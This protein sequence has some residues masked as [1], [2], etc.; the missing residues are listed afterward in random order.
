MPTPF[1]AQLKHGSDGGVRRR[2]CS[3]LLGLSLLAWLSG[4]EGDAT[5]APQAP[6]TSAIQSPAQGSLPAG[7]A[8]IEAGNY[9]VPKSEWSVADF[10]VTFPRGWTVQYG[11]V[12][13]KNSGAADELGFV[14]VEVDEIFTDACKGGDDVTEV[15]PSVYD[16]STALLRQPGPRAQGL[17]RATFGGY[18][19]I[20]VNLSVPKNLNL[21]ACSLGGIGLQ[22]WYSAPADKH[23]VLLHDG[24]ASVYILDIDGQRQ[25]F[26]VQHRSAASPK[27]IR[28]LQAVIDSIHI[29]G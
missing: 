21:K 23:F 22:I 3:L 28:E 17:F 9:L 26:L 29:E 24:V 18:P 14:A 27:D 4:C 19:A 16:L 25:V 7:T 12:Y 10:T 2:T 11:H 1:R 5:G 8:P 20:M 15:G 6:T 13:L